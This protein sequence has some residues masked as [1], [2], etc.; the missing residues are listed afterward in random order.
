ML[1]YHIAY[2]LNFH[3]DRAIGK[4]YVMSVMVI[5]RNCFL[6]WIDYTKLCMYDSRNEEDADVFFINRIE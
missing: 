2:L 1:Q 5:I 6:Q 4:K 3:A